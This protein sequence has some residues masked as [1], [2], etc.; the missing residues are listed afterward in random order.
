[1]E[2]VD[3]GAL[4]PGCEPVAVEDASWGVIKSMFR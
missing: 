3:R 1:M 2:P 4:K